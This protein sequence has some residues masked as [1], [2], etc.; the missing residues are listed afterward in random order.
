MRTMIGEPTNL[1]NLPISQP[2]KPKLL[3]VIRKLSDGRRVHVGVEESEAL[4]GG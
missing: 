4:V 3:R 2:I 1:D